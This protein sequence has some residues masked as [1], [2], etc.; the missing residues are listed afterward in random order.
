MK[1]CLKKKGIIMTSRVT[2]IAN[3][4]ATE[5]FQHSLDKSGI[6]VAA[7]I[8]QL[9]SD[10]TM[11]ES[12]NLLHKEERVE[13]RGVYGKAYLALR[14]ED[15]KNNVASGLSQNSTYHSVMNTF[16]GGN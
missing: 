4:K 3:E 16:D 7:R 1:S 12:R 6:D 9:D 2:E 15:I 10:A 13:T 11:K 14:A 8:K 5:Q